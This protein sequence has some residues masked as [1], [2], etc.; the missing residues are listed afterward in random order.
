M[1]QAGLPCTSEL[2][3]EAET[4]HVSERKSDDILII[5]THN[6]ENWTQANDT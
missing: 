3:R 2:D 6:K 1:L 5:R 4:A